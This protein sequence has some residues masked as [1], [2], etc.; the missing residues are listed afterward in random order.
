MSSNPLVASQK[1]DFSV[2]RDS[3]SANLVISRSGLPIQE[4][5][6]SDLI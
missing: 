6:C 1:S 2:P 4:S 3:E 5:P